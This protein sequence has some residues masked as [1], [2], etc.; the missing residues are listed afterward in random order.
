MIHDRRSL[1]D[2]FNESEFL[3][4][5][6][7]TA[8]AS[9]RGCIVLERPDLL[10]ELADR[11]NARDTTARGRSLAELEELSSQPSQYDPGGEIPEKSWVYRF[12][13]RLWFNDYGAYGQHFRAENWQDPRVSVATKE[14]R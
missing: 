9:T 8:A 6:R 5:F 10:R 1:R 7:Q 13:K 4:D 11:H 2:T 3:R 12:A 14:R